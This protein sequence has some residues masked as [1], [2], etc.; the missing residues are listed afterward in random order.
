MMKLQIETQ[1]KIN[2]TAEQVWETFSDF[3]N[4]KSWNPFISSI[5]GS[6]TKG[7]I[8]KADI[9]DMK[10]KPTVLKNDPAKE[11][12]WL[13]KL[14][15]KGLFDGEHYFI[16]KSINESTTLFIHG[17]HFSG[18]LVGLFKSKLLNETKQGFVAMNNALKELVEKKI[19][20]DKALVA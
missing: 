7:S 9:G 10:F 15:F 5:Q 14:Y 6:M 17:E 12:R 3:E 16:L 18:L 2:A 4:Y 19:I 1:I 8:L 20:N 11:F 13:G